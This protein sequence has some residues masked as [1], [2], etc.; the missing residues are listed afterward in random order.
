MTLVQDFNKIGEFYSHE[1]W[2]MYRLAIKTWKT[3]FGHI[4]YLLLTITLF[5]FSP[6]LIPHLMEFDTIKVFM[7]TLI[8]I[9]KKRYERYSQNY[10]I[11]CRSIIY[12]VLGYK[13]EHYIILLY[14]NLN[15]LYYIA[16]ASP[17]CEVWFIGKTVIADYCVLFVGFFMHNC[18]LTMVGIFSQNNKYA[19]WTWT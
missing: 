1:E 7:L 3:K 2:P 8:R 18:P 12:S 6:I 11:K 4:H 17:Y 16:K 13:S 15:H 5:P 19:C 10:A 9:W 14:L